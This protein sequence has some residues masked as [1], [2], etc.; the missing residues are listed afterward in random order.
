MPGENLDLSVT[1]EASQ[2]IK[3][4]EI[5]WLNPQGVKKETNQGRLRVEVA[6]R[7]DGKWTCVVTNNERESR[8][9]ILVTVVGE[10]LFLLNTTVLCKFTPILRCFYKDLFFLYLDFSP[11]SS[12]LQY[13]S[14]SAPLN[15]PCSIPAHISWDQMKAVGLQ[16][17]NWHFFPKTGSNLISK[18]PQ[19]LFHLSANDPPTWT[20]D[21]ARDLTPV[22]VLK[23]GLLSLTRSLG[24]DEDAGNYVCSMTVRKSVI[25]KRTVGVKVLQSK[26]KQIK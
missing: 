2:N 20:Q 4:P 16:E 8:A 19:R 18:E 3:T 9:E 11:D 13:T 5:H 21:Q 10:L 17:V 23:K 24:R 14:K 12:T 22:P 26:S 1:A 25:L 6:G 7:D 15:V